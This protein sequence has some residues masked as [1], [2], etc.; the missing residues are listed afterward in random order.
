MPSRL[1]PCRRDQSRVP[2]LDRLSPAST[3][4]R[5][6]RTPARH[7]PLSPSAYRD[8]LRRRGRRDGSLQFRTELCPH[9][10]L[11][12]PRAS[13]IPPELA[14]AVCCLRRDMTGSAARPFGY[15]CHGAARFAH[16]WACGLA[17]LHEAY[18]ST[19]AFDA[20]LRRPGLPERPGP[21]TRSLRRLPRRDFH[22]LAQCSMNRQPAGL[23]F[24][25]TYHCHHSNR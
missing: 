16:R 24:V 18:G 23:R 20:P 12:T 15:L 13:C 11:T 1:P 14:D 22:P 2:S 6:P 19:R 7:D 5:T 9:A 3:V 10:L 17:P 25:R 21:A 8:R 4:L